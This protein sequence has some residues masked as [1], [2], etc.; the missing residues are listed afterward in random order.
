MLRSGKIENANCVAYN[1]LEENE[2]YKN[3][4]GEIDEFDHVIG[5]DDAVMTIIEYA[6]FQCPGC[7]WS[8]TELLD[9]Q[10][11]HADEIRVVFRHYPLDMHKLAW[12]ATYFAEAAGEQNLFF[13]FSRFLYETQEEWDSM[14]ST[15]FES[16]I[17][18]KTAENFPE[19]DIEK[20]M[21]DYNSEELHNRIQAKFEPADKSGLI[22]ATPTLLINYTPFSNSFTEISLNN[23]LD[24]HR[25]KN[26]ILPECPEFKIDVKKEYKAVLETT[27]GTI[28]IDLFP[29]KAPL[30][31]ANTIIL[32][33]QGWYDNM[34][35]TAVNDG[36]AIQFGDPSASGYLN[37]G[38]TFAYERTKDVE[39]GHGYISLLKDMS[40]KN[41]SIILL[42]LDPVDYY[43]QSILNDDEIAPEN[44]EDYAV[45]FA[46]IDL[47]QE[48]VFGKI[49]EETYHVAEELDKNDVILSF[50]V[51]E[52][53]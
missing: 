2:A 11:K 35:L 32:A 46:A 39:A 13:E 31:V 26:R 34:P 14:T 45:Q 48:T 36:Y 50:T 20:F 22:Y 3:A 9:Y 23:W 8:S 49:T 41:S 12:K 21:E 25:Y 7:A 27:K 17:A 29:D 10:A 33:E 52:S 28:E 30:A 53:D 19:I 5:P 40:G 47:S 42:W 37:S 43:Y 4:F 44:K 51:I 38:Y 16:W 1:P 24:I 18:E 6:D 15:K